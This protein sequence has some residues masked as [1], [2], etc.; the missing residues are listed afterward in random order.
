MFFAFFDAKNTGRSFHDMYN[1]AVVFL[2]FPALATV[3]SIY[4]TSTDE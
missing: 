2:L 4:E 1:F 3:F